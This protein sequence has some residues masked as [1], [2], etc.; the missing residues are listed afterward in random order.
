MI[1]VAI[2]GVDGNMGGLVAKDVLRDENLELV[3]G[4][5]LPESPNEGKDIGVFH[6]WNPINIPIT[7]SEKLTSVLQKTKPDV[8]VDFTTAHATEK[9]CIIVADQKIKCVIGTTALSPEFLRKFEKSVKQNGTCAVISP[10]MSLGINSLFKLAEQLTK[11]LPDYDIEIIE[12][13]HNRKQ[14][15][16]SGTAMKL[17]QIIASS[18]DKDIEEIGSFGRARGT[19]PR[20]IGPDEIGIHSIRAGDIVGDHTILFAGPGERL[21]ITHR[22]HSREC[23]ATGTLIAIKF[24]VQKGQPGRIYSMQ[25]VLGL[26]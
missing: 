18:L 22:A 20:K 1:K 25:D 26:E 19:T 13:H 3:A 21:E 8:Y 4:F 9:N 16:P 7:S 24:L 23:F 15:V 6:G 11:L 5:T 14:D 2:A 10:N 12:A 17:A